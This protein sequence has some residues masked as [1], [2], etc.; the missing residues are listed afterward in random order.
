MKT[1]E[2]TVIASGLDPAADDFENRFY[3]AGCDDATIAFQK[4]HIIVDFARRAESIAE[5]ILSALEVV[6]A[7]GAHIDRIEPDPLV[8]LSDI[9]MRAG[10]TRAAI[11]LYANGR[12]GQGFPPPIA[13]ITSDSALWD[14]AAVAGWLF[15]HDRLPRDAVVVAKIVRQ[16]TQAL[17]SGEQQV[18]AQLK[19]RIH[20]FDLAL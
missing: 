7:A 18:D 2:F 5:A 17:D 14:W 12:R 13:K 1:Y 16:I 8:S 19:Q 3:E 20:A 6:A 4:G 9:A 15:E 11:S 10:M